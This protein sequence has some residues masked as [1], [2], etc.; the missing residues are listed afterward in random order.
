MLQGCVWAERGRLQ[1][2]QV[3]GSRCNHVGNLS[4]SSENRGGINTSSNRLKLQKTRQ[5]RFP[6]LRVRGSCPLLMEQTED[7]TPDLLWNSWGECT[8]HLR[9]SCEAM[10]KSRNITLVKISGWEIHNKTASYKKNIQSYEKKFAH[11]Y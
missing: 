11:P 8:C 5:S 9:S 3:L 10:P 2:L 7:Q 1:R 6:D 4:A